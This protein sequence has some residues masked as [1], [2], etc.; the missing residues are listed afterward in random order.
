MLP[1]FCSFS[2]STV[3]ERDEDEGKRETEEAEYV[4]L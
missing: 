3:M 4:T 2:P 1:A